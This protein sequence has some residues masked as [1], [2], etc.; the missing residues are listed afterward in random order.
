MKKI[1]FALPGNEL[2]TLQLI[3]KENGE[4]GLAEI[5]QFPDEETYI[6]ILS[7]VKDKNVYLVC[8]LHK[9]DTKLLPLFF[10]S[11]TVKKMGAKK[12]CLIAPYLAYMRQDTIFNPGESVTSIYFAALISSFT[13]QLITIDP[14]LHRWNS[15][16]EIYTIPT[17]MRH[18]ANLISLWIKNNIDN[19]LNH[20]NLQ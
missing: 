10:L 12:V 11:K 20:Q 5:R 1:F 14:H 3:K 15:L 6:R 18:A 8:T 16:S 13:D 7:D 17:K 19:Q 4:K 2:L 9:P